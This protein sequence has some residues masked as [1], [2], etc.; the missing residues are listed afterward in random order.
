MAASRSAN[1][2]AVKCLPWVISGQLHCNRSCPL[3]SQKRTYVLQLRMSA[4]GRTF[5]VHSITI[6]SSA[7]KM[8]PRCTEV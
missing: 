2:V 1:T 3:Y 6:T 4:K 7:Q 5:T 8:P